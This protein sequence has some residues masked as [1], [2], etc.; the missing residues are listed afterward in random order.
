MVP[1]GDTPE[2]KEGG[3]AAG[4][5]EILLARRMA[6]AFKHLCFQ[7]GVMGRLYHLYELSS[8]SANFTTSGNC[9]RLSADH[10][11]FE[12]AKAISRYFTPPRW[13][14][15]LGL[16][17]HVG[18]SH[19]MSQ[20][21]SSKEEAFRHEA[22]SQPH[23]EWQFI[24]GLETLQSTTVSCWAR[25]LFKNKPVRLRSLALRFSRRH[26]MTADE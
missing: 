6:T 2:K 3:N 8:E 19:R 1:G 24:F 4:G 22:F 16:L 25:E 5:E 15:A 18:K 7:T 26:L 17:P 12:Y 9:E 23:P 21:T 13:L 14:I 11:P 20:E 10:L